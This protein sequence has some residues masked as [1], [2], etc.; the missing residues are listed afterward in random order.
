MDQ[1][2]PYRDGPTW[3]FTNSVSMGHEG[4]AVRRRLRGL[5]EHHTLFMGWTIGFLDITT[6][7]HAAMATWIQGPSLYKLG[8]VPRDFLK[9]S[10]WTVADTVRLVSTNPEERI[11]IRNEIHD[12][13]R[14]F[15]YRIRRV[16]EACLLWQWLFP[17]RMPDFDDNWH[18]DGLLFPRQGDYPE[19]SIEVIGVGGASTSRHY[20]R[21]KD[22]DLIGK[23][24][25][26]SKATMQ[27]AKDD[28]ALATHLLVD[29][30][31]SRLDTYGTRW[32]AHDLYVD[33]MAEEDELDIF[34]CG[35]TDK[36]GN[37]LFPRRFPPAVLEKIKRRIGKRR[38]SL[39]MLNETP[40]EGASELS[41]AD[42]NYYS[43][44]TD[45]YGRK[46]FVLH[47]ADGED[48]MVWFRDLFI[49]QTLDPNVTPDSKHARS[50]SV[51][52]GLARPRNEWSHFSILILS[53]IA[54]ATTPKGAIEIAHHEYTFWK[55]LL[56][57]IEIVAAQVTL[58]EWMLTAHP[59]MMIKGL[60][61]DHGAP[62][63]ARIRSFTPYGENGH[64]FVHPSLKDFVEEWEDFPTG[65]MD[66]LDA[67]AYMPYIWTIPTFG[68][69][70]PAHWDTRQDLVG[71][72]DQVIEDEDRPDRTHDGRSPITGY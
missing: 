46:F 39:Q 38:Y 67:L 17:E 16:P 33:M 54:K 23:E 4:D 13:V 24:A 2:G 59:E 1:I 52:V 35:P 63:L 8:L 6:G 15:L 49:Y 43:R 36:F 62:K 21:I 32:A 27:M 14:K 40:R 58:K 55:P 42:L 50:A 53:A 72:G 22:D 45:Q 10:L 68:A 51:V 3:N 26:R 9:T 61:P 41:V 28:H 34:H 47:H 37:A 19:L 60:H 69:D 7:I 65:T 11:L 57:G 30:E 56:F 44:S 71:I 66:I 20:T 5:A 29:P 18:Q 64:I 31:T 48:E 70:T 12:N 25:A